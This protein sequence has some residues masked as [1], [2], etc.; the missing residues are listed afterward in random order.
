MTRIAL[1]ALGMP[2]IALRGMNMPERW[3]SPPDALLAGCPGN[4]EKR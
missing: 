3:L 4:I 1:D 2:T